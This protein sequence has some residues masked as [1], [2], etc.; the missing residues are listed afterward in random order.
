MVTKFLFGL[1]NQETFGKL[2]EC[3]QSCQFPQDKLEM[4]QDLPKDSIYTTIDDE[5]VCY[6]NWAHQ[7]QNDDF[8]NRLASRL[9]GEVDVECRMLPSDFPAFY[10]VCNKKQQTITLN[11]LLKK[12]F[13]G[14]CW[15]KFVSDP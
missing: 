8:T 11:K 10:Y 9:N 3:I 13:Y 4:L 2:N 1:C 14:N 12:D 7:L 5:V 15:K 6:F